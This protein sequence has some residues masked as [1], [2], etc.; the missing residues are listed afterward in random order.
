[1]DGPVD[2]SR[3]KTLMERLLTERTVPAGD[4]DFE[5]LN[6]CARE[7][8]MIAAEI[9]T[10]FH[11]WPEIAELMGKLTGKPVPE[12]FCLFPPVYSDFG[13]NIKFGKGVFINS[14]CCFQGHG[15]ITIGDGCQ[16]GH[17]V[18]FATVN[19]GND[20]ERRHDLFVAPIVLRKNVWVGAHATILPGVTIG[21]DSIVAAGSVVT[22][23]VPPMTIVAGVPAKPVKSLRKTEVE[24]AEGPVNVLD[25]R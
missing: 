22:H 16:I 8:Q 13:R 14:G 9:N 7:A 1:M 21:H 15:G 2:E 23:N 5:V 12:G 11:E 19:H 20:P 25:Q 4:P 6:A 18:V 10:G 24:P 17:Q 3:I